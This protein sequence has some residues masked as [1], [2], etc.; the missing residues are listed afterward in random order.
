L[1]SICYNNEEHF[2]A[3]TFFLN[4]YRIRGTDIITNMAEKNATVDA[5]MTTYN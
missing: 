2:R 3:I 1:F 5:K 4:I